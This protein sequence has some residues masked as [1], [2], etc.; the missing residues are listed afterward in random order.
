MN[1][2]WHPLLH[3]TTCLEKGEKYFFTSS[4]YIFPHGNKY[5]MTGSKYISLFRWNTWSRVRWIYLTR[6]SSACGCCSSASTSTQDWMNTG[7]SGCVLWVSTIHHSGG[8]S[9]IS[10]IAM[11]NL[12][13]S[14]Q[15]INHVVP[16]HNNTHSLL[17]K[18]HQIT[19]AVM[20]HA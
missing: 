4:P 20:Y 1:S 7:Y 9:I 8:Q 3:P 12:L 10:G 18:S 19:K 6:L 14:F 11:S 2:F 16:H 17:L 13:S 5:I 15:F